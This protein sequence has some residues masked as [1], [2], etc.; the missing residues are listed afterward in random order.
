MLD[1]YKKKAQQFDDLNRKLNGIDPAT[2]IKKMK[3]FDKL[4]KALGCDPDDL[5]KELER[6]K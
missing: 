4:S 5:L 6:L 3:D 2:L 1:E